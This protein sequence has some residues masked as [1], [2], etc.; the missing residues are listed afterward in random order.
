M[1]YGLGRQS[2]GD[3]SLILR[4]CVPPHPTPHFYGGM[5]KSAWHYCKSVLQPNT[6]TEMDEQGKDR[7]TRGKRGSN[8]TIQQKR[9]WADFVTLCLIGRRL[10]DCS[11]GP[12]RRRDP[13]TSRAL[14]ILSTPV[15]FVGLPAG[16]TVSL[17]LLVF[18]A[19][20]RGP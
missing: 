10:H 3:S 14:G 20:S 2:W 4:P 9:P 15:V 11:T 8:P 1:G 7:G 18:N 13:S 12:C 16:L 6:T 19:A 5:F 17:W